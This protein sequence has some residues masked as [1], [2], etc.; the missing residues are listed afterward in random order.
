NV[1]GSLTPVGDPPLFLGY[2]KGVPFWWVAA[3]CWPIWVTGVGVLLLMFFIVDT[4]NFRRASATVRELETGHERWRFEGLSNLAFLAVILGATLINHPPFLREV[5]MLCAAAGSYFTTSK[6][7]HESNHF[8][9][10]PI[11]EVA[12]LFAGI[13]ATMI[14]ALDWLQT[15]AA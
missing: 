3:R 8:S 2:L 4:K 9:F 15:N 12:V 11:K 13:F 1:G 7:I 6:S 5:L 14:P 10:H